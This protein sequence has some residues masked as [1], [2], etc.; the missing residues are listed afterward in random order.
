MIR[1]SYAMKLAKTKLHSKR[2]MLVASIVVASLLFAALIAM[3]IVFTGAEKSATAFIKKAGN[4]RYLVKVSPHI[5]YDKVDFKQPLSLEDV[6]TIKAA[7]KQYYEALK[8]TYKSLGIEYSKEQE[9]P[10]LKPAAYFSESMPEE[11]RVM[12]NWD[13]PVIESLRGQRFDTY[14]K[15]ADN[16][17]DDLQRIGAQYDASGYFLVGKASMISPLPNLRLIQNNKEDFSASEQKGGSS[18]QGVYTHAVYNGSYQFTDQHILSRYLTITD[19]TGLKGIPVVISAQEAVSLFGEKVGIGKE[20]DDAT[21]KR[22]WLEDIQKKLSGT[23]YQACYRNSA[24]QAML[25]K[26]QR[27]YAE[28]KGNEGNKNYQ[29]PSLIYDYPKEACG[30][31]VLKED[32]R[33]AIEKRADTK[34]EETEKKL[35]T[36]SA[37]THKMLTFQIVGVKYAEPYTDYTKGIDEYIKNLLVSQDNAMAVDIPIQMYDSLPDAVKVGD[38]QKEYSARVLRYGMVD[39]DLATRVLEFPSVE[40]ARAFLNAETCP[41]SEMNC[42]RRFLASPYGSNYLILDEISNLF[43][44]IASIAFPAALGL[45]AA[46]IWFTISRIMAENRKETAIY[47]AM[48]AKRR[49][50][51]GIYLVYVLL[52]ALQVAVASAVL[53]IAT[54][55]AVDYFYGKALTDTAVAVF[56]IVDNAPTFSLFNLESPLLL[57]IVGLIFAICMIASIQPLIRN[58]RR[59]PIRDMREDS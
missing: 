23:T 22:A 11:Q 16:K 54:A 7:E 26:I 33:T 42:N 50:V 48:G 43:N 10:A 14:I 53:G 47:R 20:P 28:A 8:D 39:D 1:P 12:I 40:K 17:I 9:I 29:K 3:V 46:I 35:G 32:T 58:V 15:T 6:R 59:S 52:V 4:D 25:D 45:A 51:T 31:I 37:P 41:D 38:I 36:Y 55:F 49:D 24:E 27:D 19:S 21:D 56:G 57:V 2:G 13:S 34:A 5:P 44:R 30:A 18:V